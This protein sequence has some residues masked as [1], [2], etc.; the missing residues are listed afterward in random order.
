MS[1]VAAS[2]KRSHQLLHVYG[3][4][5]AIV[6]AGV[7]ASLILAGHT[8]RFEE[9]RQ[10]RQFDLRVQ[11]A[12]TAIQSRFAA[13]QQV[14]RGAVALFNASSE[15][16]RETW[17]SYVE[18]LQTDE[19]FPG[20]Q[21]IGYAVQLTHDA[22]AA[23]EAEVRADGYPDYRV[24]PVVPERAPTAIMYLEPFDARNQRAFG[25]DMYSQITRRTAMARARDTGMPALSGRVTLLQETSEDRQAGT[26]LYLPVYRDDAGAATVAERRAS[27]LGWVYSPFRM[28]D[29]M[30]GILGEE[31]AHIRLRIYDGASINADELLFD[32]RDKQ[33]AAEPESEA[34]HLRAE[35]QLQVAGQGWTLVLD[36]R[37]GFFPGGVSS[38]NVVAAAGALLTLM[39]AL[40]LASLRGARDRALGMAA[41][42]TE[43]LSESEKTQ[44]AVVENTADGIITFDE[45]ARILSSNRAAQKMFGY[46]SSALRGRGLD[47]LLPKFDLPEELNC[48][49]Q[50]GAVSDQPYRAMRMDLSGQRQ[51]GSEF[52]VGLAINVIP[53]AGQRQF[54][55]LLT[56][57]TE[58]VAFEQ[59]LQ[60]MA[61]HDALT[62]LPNRTLLRDR[63]NQAITQARRNHQHAAVMML[64][65]DHFKRINDSLGHKVGDD[66]LLDVAARLR[67]A[68]RESDTVA[69]MGGDEFVVLLPVVDGEESVRAV[70]AK[71]L[72]ELSRPYRIAEREMVIT[73]SVGI[74]R[75]PEDG[76]DEF[77]LLQKADAAMYS[78]KASGRG[79]YR[80]FDA[81]MLATNHRRLE[82]EGA[83][84]K[85]VENEEL[86][87]AYQKQISLETG[88]LVGCEAL[89]RWHSPV[90]G[91]VSP[92]HFVPIAEDLGIIHEL[93]NWVIDQACMDARMMH[94]ELEHPFMMAVNVSPKQFF[95]GD[96]VATVRRALNR[97][98]L[99]PEWLELEITEG[100]LI[101]NPKETIQT[102]RRLRNM[103]VRVAI[104][105]FGTGFS[106]LSYLMRY[107]IDKL[108]IDRSF[109]NDLGLDQHDA[110]LTAAIIAMA[111]SIGLMVVAEGVETTEQG[112]FLREFGC[113]IVQGFYFGKP[114][115][116]DGF[117]RS[118]DDIRAHRAMLLATRPRPADKSAHGAK[119]AH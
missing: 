53:R 44:R 60:H 86:S 12:V 27:L 69:R 54:V 76:E 99:A 5:A 81:E 112:Q 13:Y 97:S 101:E 75:F 43:A 51:D 1:V 32:N 114:L 72:A 7:V 66:L 115:R 117:L 61:Q 65:L 6:V 94:I 58:R 15:V 119:M 96:I 16:T 88:E 103:G 63:L 104:D 70:A 24:H 2:F 9:E 35:V 41:D 57:K 25:Y 52:P 100:V 79:Q 106:S 49:A 116:T 47:Q 78:A 34:G 89:L 31:L 37:P 93:G 71:I 91:E 39:L 38:A 18:S 22:L 3:P 74:S 105:D 48:E 4:V 14:L 90:L 17:R 62:E 10:Q 23:H 64:D 108:K 113:D 118:A 109:I 8:G 67:G 85:A 19:H 77:E 95:Y 56:D 33:S 82:I 107:P 102:L 30:R 87:L 36:T 21:G 40:V 73:P 111:H 80:F 50:I 20:I 28:N 68:V 29:L 110:S 46:G 55:A 11:E 84:R 42:M 83:L 59:R 26:L 98:G 45:Q 92:E